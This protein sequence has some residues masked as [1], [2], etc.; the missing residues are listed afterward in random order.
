M[1][2]EFTEVDALDKV[3]EQFRGMYKQGADN[4]FSLDPTFKGVAEAVTGLNKSLKAA[5]EEAKRKTP[6]DLTLL[7]DFGDTPETIKAGIDTKLKALQDEIAKGGEAKLN[8]DKVRQELSEANAKALKQAGA[9]SEAL[10][11]QLYQLMVENAATSAVAELKGVPELLL[12]FIKNQV[13]VIEQDG[14][15]KVFVVDAQ[16]DQRYSGVTGQ[17]MTIKE[18]V[19][20]MK[21][22]EKYGRLFESETQPGGGMTPGGG[23][24]VPRPTGRELTANEKIAVGLSKGQFRQPGRR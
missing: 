17:P 10:Q 18:L 16:G 14:S 8:L 21:A 12:P 13:K 3:P 7:H 4:K 24:S 20:E 19:T 15:F 11:N 1:E 2:F 5:R 23:R 22:N 6:V 9:R